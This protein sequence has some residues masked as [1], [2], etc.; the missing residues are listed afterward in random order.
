MAYSPS[1]ANIGTALAPSALL[2]AAVYAIKPEFVTYAVAVAGILAGYL[3]FSN[4]TFL[5]VSMG[6]I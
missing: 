4:S 1:V 3:V 2:V 5:S 6:V